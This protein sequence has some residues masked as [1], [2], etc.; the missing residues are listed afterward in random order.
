MPSGCVESGCAYLYLYDDETSGRR[1][2]GCMRKVFRS[3]I[4]VDLFDEA[5]RTRQGYG[6]VA[7][8]GAPLPRCRVVVER[9]YDGEGAAFA[10]TNPA[11][12]DP[13]AHEE[14][15]FDLRDGL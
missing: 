1:F 6:G 2:M 13:P 14:P 9:A 10:C 12:L 8:A 11:F 5:Q 7:M 3:E 15:A 4:D